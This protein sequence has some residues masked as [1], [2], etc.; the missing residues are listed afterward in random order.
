[1]RAVAPIALLLC[2]PLLA[3]A[4]VVVSLQPVYDDSSVV[5]DQALVGN[6]VNAEEETSVAIERAEWRSY[7]VA[8]TDRFATRNFH[9]NLTR[10]GDATWLDLTEVRGEEGGPFLLP[11]HGVYR[12]SVAGDVLSASPLEYGW[13]T[14][15]IDQKGPRGLNAIVDGRRNVVIA[16]PTAELRK[17]LASA[18]A[19][20]VGVP[21]NYKRAGGAAGKAGGAGGS[22][23]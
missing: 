11:V 18:P 12:V 1:M 13:M 22:R 15:A 7:K 10:I 4:C 21:T 2:L 16:S 14:R 17:W 19:E 3:S 20:A 5:F 6:W 9:G 8:Y 23:Q